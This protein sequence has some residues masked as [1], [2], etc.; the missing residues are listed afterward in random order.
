VR[1]IQVLMTA[2]LIALTFCH[3]TSQKRNSTI[4]LVAFGEAISAGQKSASEPI[5]TALTFRP[6]PNLPPTCFRHE[7]LQC[8]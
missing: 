4:G 8:F 7:G 2:V 3:H 6:A 5:I 1:A